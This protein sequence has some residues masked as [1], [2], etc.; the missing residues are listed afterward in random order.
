MTKLKKIGLPGL[1]L[2]AASCSVGCTMCCSPY[3]SDYIGTGGKHQ[4]T[5]PRYGRVGSVFSDPTFS[6]GGVSEGIEMVD[7][8]G[9]SLPAIEGDLIEPIQILPSE[10]IS[11]EPV[12][13]EPMPIDSMR[14]ES[15]PDDSMPGVLIE[16]SG[17]N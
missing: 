10:P 15:M 4:R 6:N 12:S 9:I 5:D 11:G 3:D 16:P 17:S 2:L 1:V 14:I 8:F 7:D 13:G